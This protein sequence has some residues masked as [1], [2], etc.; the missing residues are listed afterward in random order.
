VFATTQEHERS[1]EHN[2]VTAVK[3]FLQQV[4]DGDYDSDL[5]EKLFSIAQE[6]PQV[7]LNYSLFRRFSV[8]TTTWEVMEEFAARAPLDTVI[9]HYEEF[10]STS[11]LCQGIVAERLKEHGEDNLLFDNSK[12][13]YGKLVERILTLR[14]KKANLVA[15]KL[16]PIAERRLKQL[17]SLWDLGLIR[18]KVAVFGD[19]SASMQ[20]A[21]EA[22]AIFASMVSVC[23][24][25]ELSFFR[26][27]LLAS[28]YAKPS[29]VHEALQ[30]CEQIRADG[31]TS[32]ASALWPY[33]A[34]NI[35]YGHICDGHG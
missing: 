10:H 15:E 6:F 8:L 28:P 32:L 20:N 30:V 17:Q 23:F 13:T 24:D 5:A 35:K 1:V 29:N 22:A 14:R 18:K 34:N 31:T 3:L 26:A 21:I 9:W 4:N 33:Y 19:A 16:V 11:H 12:V 2:F 7:Y 27:D 25:G